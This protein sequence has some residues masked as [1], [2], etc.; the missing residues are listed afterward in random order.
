MPSLVLV[1]ALGIDKTPLLWYD[2]GSCLRFVLVLV[3]VLYMV[4][5]SWY[6]LELVLGMGRPRLTGCGAGLGLVVGLV[7]ALVAVA[8]IVSAHSARYEHAAAFRV[9][10][11]MSAWPLDV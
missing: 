11:V 6:G 1:L 9:C 5:L 10:V 3:F 8:V 4:L 2:A 7:P